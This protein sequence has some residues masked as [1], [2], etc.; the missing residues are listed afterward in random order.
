MPTPHTAQD[1]TTGSNSCQF[2]CRLMKILSD[3]R[4][5]PPPWSAPWRPNQLS[6]SP[7]LF[8]RESRQPVV[9]QLRDQACVKAVRAE[10]RLHHIIVASGREHGESAA[11]LGGQ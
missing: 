11:L 1:R 6:A 7:H 3:A 5:V 9:R 2:V 4:P 10:Q 8:G